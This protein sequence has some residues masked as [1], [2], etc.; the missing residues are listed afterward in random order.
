MPRTNAVVFTGPSISHQHASSIYKEAIYLPPAS[1]GDVYKVCEKYNPRL[2][3]IVDGYFETQPAVWHKEILYALSKGIHVIGAASMGALRAAELHTYGMIGIGEVYEAYKTGLIEDDDEVAIVHAPE[4][5]QYM[6]LSEAM[7]NIRKTVALG[8]QQK[9]LPASLAQYVIDLAKA[10]YYKQRCY[11]RLEE[12]ACQAHE[13]L[14]DFFIWAE[15]K[16]CNAKHD[17][18]ALMLDYIKDFLMD[19]DTVSQISFYFEETAYWRQCIVE[20]E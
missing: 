14:R 15:Q 11:P 5:L 9:I 12:T 17:D 18:A 3:G 6:P 4:D 16:A 8:V 20:A 2:I 7:V 13:S 19:K 1:Q 10:M